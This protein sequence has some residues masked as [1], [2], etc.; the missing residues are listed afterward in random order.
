MRL[1]SA[2]VFQKQVIKPH[3]A[4]LEAIEPLDTCSRC[5]G[6]IPGVMQIDK[7]SRGGEYDV[8]LSG[9][10]EAVTDDSPRVHDDTQR[11]RCA[12]LLAGADDGLDA[13]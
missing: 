11:L 9:D 1:R 8:T 6:E 2:A 12:S 3:Q 7:G 13:R 5:P 4:Q 10:S